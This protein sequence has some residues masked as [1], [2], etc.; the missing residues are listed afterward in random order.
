MSYYFHR[1]QMEE[2]QK[3]GSIRSSKELSGYCVSP[4][5]LQ[6][7][8]YVWILEILP[9]ASLAQMSSYAKVCWVKFSLLTS[10]WAGFLDFYAVHN[11][12]PLFLFDL[13]ETSTVASKLQPHLFWG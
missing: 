4:F 9:C 5:L 11:E 12:F 7:D 8:L 6:K 10:I 1:T 3:I 2:L 13:M